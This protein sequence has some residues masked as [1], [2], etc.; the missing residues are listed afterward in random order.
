MKL[1]EINCLKEEIDRSHCLKD[2][3]TNICTIPN[4]ILLSIPLVVT[5]GVIGFLIYQ[6]I[7]RDWGLTNGTTLFIEIIIGIIISL[8]LLW[9]AK[10]NELEMKR[11]VDEMSDILRQTERDRMKKSTHIY[12]LMLKSLNDINDIVTKI[13]SI[14]KMHED[15]N[16]SSQDYKKDILT[17][18]AQLVKSL[19]TG[20]DDPVNMN[21]EFF[22]DRMASSIQ[23]ISKNCKNKPNFSV[24]HPIADAPFYDNLHSDIA[25]VIEDLHGSFSDYSYDHMFSVSTDRSVYPL[26]S[27]IYVQANI[28]YAIDGVPIRF[29][30]L[31]SKGKLID[32][33]TI[34]IGPKYLTHPDSGIYEIDFK[35][36][37][38]DWKVHKSYTVRATYADKSEEDSFTIDQRTPVIQTDKCVYMTDSDMIVTVIDPDSDKDN[39]A[40]EYVGNRRDSKLT[41]TSKDDKIGTYELEETGNSTGIFQGVIGI[42]GR[43][44][45]GT[46]IP[47]NTGTEII[48]K[49]QGTG[50]EDGYI[51]AGPGD[52]II[53]TY[54]YGSKTVSISCFVTAFTPLVELDKKVYKPNDKVQITITDPDHKYEV[55]TNGEGQKTITV[56]IKIGSNTLNG[57]QLFETKSDFKVFVGELSLKKCNDGQ[58]DSQDKDDSLDTVP[59]CR[60]GDTIIVTYTSLEDTVIVK[61]HIQA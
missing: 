25:A 32:T 43:R 57:Y 21:K 61:A 42:L 49:T 15:K 7:I 35:M 37:G 10:T 33:E 40:V 1:F 60:D 39:E 30:L 22:S 28:P 31:N 19:K 51:A 54:Q 56:N 18:H 48:K 44:K 11:K 4:L 20:L 2:K 5:S 8:F 41:I 24:R 12:R 16:S 23:W 38:D 59:C 6:N 55:Q 29:E 34:N 36:E 52:E 58:P 53:F 47:Y 27:K 17:L 9:T 3:I 50:G 46:V 26:E 45:D 13:L 14:Y